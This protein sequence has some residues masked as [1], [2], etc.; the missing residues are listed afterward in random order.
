MLGD[1]CYTNVINDEAVS[2]MD[3]IKFKVCTSDNKSPSY[4]IVD[5]EVIVT[6]GGQTATES[7]NVDKLLNRALYKAG[8]VSNN[9]LRQEENLVVALTEQYKE[10]R[11]VFD[12][13]LKWIEHKIYC[14]FTDKSLAGKTFVVQE[15]NKDFKMAKT[16]LRLI[17][18]A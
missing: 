12:C 16:N 4:S 5:Y 2:E 15:M 8:K 9:G 1:T 14:A 13:N 11:V 17:E 18:K 7:K 3:E 6:T 10:P